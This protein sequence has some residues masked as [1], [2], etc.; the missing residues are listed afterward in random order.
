M[1]LA[2]TFFLSMQQTGGAGRD[3]PA[4]AR[5]REYLSLIMTLILGF[6]ICFQLPVV[7]TLLARAGIV[8]ADVLREQA[9][10]RDRRHLR[11]RRDPDAARPDQP[12]R[13]WRSRRCSST[14]SRSVAVDRVV[15]RQ[16]GRRE[17]AAEAGARRPEPARPSPH[18]PAGSACHKAL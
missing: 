3:S 6:G 7:L 12:D 13:A 14:R 15:K 16:P 8:D 10:L 11:R 9:A 4:G 1:P 17:A 5:C 2:M 18:P